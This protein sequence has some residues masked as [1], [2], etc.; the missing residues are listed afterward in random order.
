MVDCTLGRSVVRPDSR[1]TPAIQG[2]PRSKWLTALGHHDQGVAWLQP[3]TCPTWLDHATFAALPETLVGREVR[4][5]VSTPEF[6]T[7][8]ITLV[9]TLLDAGLYSADDRATLYGTRWEVETHLRH[10]K[11]AMHMD[12]LHGK[13]V[14]GVLKDLTIFAIIDNLV[15]M[16]IL[17]S[18]QLPRV[19]AARISFLDALQWFGAPS[20][21]MPV[22]ALIINPARPHR[23]EP[24][25]R[26][27]RP[28]N[29]P[30]I[31]KPRQ[32]LRIQLMKQALGASLHA[33]RVYPLLSTSVVMWGNRAR[34]IRAYR[35]VGHQS[36]QRPGAP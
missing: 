22:A 28:K 32:E 11:T 30:F 2:L 6:R 7:R 16:V 4:Y 9:T 12:V 33:I 18:A 24:G 17:P 5:Q 20:T 25:V 29:F 31:S 27:R 1:R 26:K 19:D 35:D 8:Q 36:G 23:V 14:A 15:R 21:G 3:K 10:L 13:T 34:A